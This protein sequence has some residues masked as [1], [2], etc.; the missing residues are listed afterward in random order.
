MSGKKERDMANSGRLGM[1]EPAGVRKAEGNMAA[2][3]FSEYAIGVRTLK[4]GE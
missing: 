4:P 3:V 2:R 1:W